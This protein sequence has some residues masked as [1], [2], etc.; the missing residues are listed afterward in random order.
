MALRKNQNF[1][2]A[3]EK[4]QFTDAVIALKAKA[5]EAPVIYTMGSLVRITTMFPMATLVLLFSLGTVSS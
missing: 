3:T 5:G 2:S 1:L 4:K